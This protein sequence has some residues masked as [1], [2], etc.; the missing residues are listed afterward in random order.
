MG[1]TSLPQAAVARTPAAR[2][3]RAVFFLSHGDELDLA[4]RRRR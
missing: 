2:G 4:S 3:W 1:D